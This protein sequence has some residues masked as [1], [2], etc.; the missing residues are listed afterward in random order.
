MTIRFK[1]L[2]L[3]SGAL[4]CM[5][6]FSAPVF[7][8]DLG[9]G[10]YARELHKMEMMKMLDADGNHMV[11]NEEFTKFYEATFDEL[12]TDH[13]GSLDA[14]EWVGVGGSKEAMVGT[15]GYNRELHKMALMKAMDTDGDHK[16][17]KSEF[18]KFHQDTFASMDKNGD[19]QLD[20]QEWLAKQT[21]NK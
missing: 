8:A 9:T 14:K 13:D 17:T 10:G 20:P 7:S 2:A 16:V 19:K 15:G 1:N 3:T 5:A 12:D 6:A 11:T 4:L 18:L 21:G